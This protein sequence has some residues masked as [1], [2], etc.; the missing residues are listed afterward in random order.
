[1]STHI[2]NES[3]QKK[4]FSNYRFNRRQFL[5]LT[6]ST[7]L[8]SACMGTPPA[9]E[10]PTESS[11]ESEAAVEPQAGGLLRLVFAGQVTNLD[12]HLGWTLPDFTLVQA[13][14]EGLVWVDGSDPAYPVR[15][16]LAESWESD[17]GGKV[18]TFKLR[19]GVSFTNEVPLTA[20]DVVHSFLNRALNPDVPFAWAQSV[21]YIES[22][23]TIDTETLQI[24]LEAPVAS[25]LRDLANVP[26]V[27]RDVAAE[28]LAE[29]SVGTGPFMLSNYVPGDHISL[30][31]NETYWDAPRPYLDELQILTLPE[32]ATQ[33]A[34]LTSGSVEALWQLGLSS[35]SV[36]E[37]ETRINLLENPLG[38][39]DVVIMKVNDAPFDDVRVRQA[40][41]YAIDRAVLVNI[42]LQGYG[43]PAN[44]QPIPPSSPFWGDVV[45]PTYDLEKAKA[46]LSEAGYPDGIELTLVTAPIRASWGPMAVAMQEMMKPAGINITIERVPAAG[47]WGG[48]LAQANFGMSW[49]VNYVDPSFF[50]STDYHSDGIY[51]F[52]GWH[53]SDLDAL[54]D[55]GVVAQDDGVRQEIYT[56][57]QQMISEEGAVLIPYYRADIKAVRSNVHGLTPDVVPLFH[58]VWLAQE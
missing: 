49:G 55:D 18:W 46:L 13:L 38:D 37:N 11:T 47:Y 39:F 1:M 52:T 51:N 45:F 34:A 6:G 21:D 23:E 24:T 3:R 40:L 12:P 44:D 33:V 2:T 43:Q 16:R 8:L 36:L 25:F 48:P 20:D 26:I 14:Y 15:P 32:E 4:S 30:V 7:M 9:T 29:T 5:W 17:D 54:L 50:L 27:P 10:V 35:V 31:R 58:S 57:V 53:N 41:K 42:A 19:Q 22:V 28:E 56:Q